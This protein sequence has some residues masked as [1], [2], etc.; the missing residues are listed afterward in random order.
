V[1]FT[2]KIDFE[3]SAS[4]NRFVV[5]SGV[6]PDLDEKKRTYNGLPDFMT[7]IARQELANLSEDIQECNVI[8]LPQLGYLLAIPKGDSMEEEDDFEI[9]GLQFVVSPSH[10]LI[11][12]LICVQWHVRQLPLSV[13]PHLSIAKSVCT[14][15]CCLPPTPACC[16][17]DLPY[18]LLSLAIFGCLNIKYTVT[19][20]GSIA[21]LAL[22]LIFANHSQSQ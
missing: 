20:I 16:R 6:D 11:A 22:M 17:V 9:E 14:L 18:L 7:E 1:L 21:E 10:N 15:I 8:Y 13:Y 2:F 3:E 19:K 4:A 12:L 5:K